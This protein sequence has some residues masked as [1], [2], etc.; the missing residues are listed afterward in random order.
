MNYNYN[1]SDKLYL[2]NKKK[3]S[4][5]LSVYKLIYK[6]KKKIEKKERKIKE[7][8]QESKNVF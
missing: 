3:H 6:K 2:V 4:F 5:S 7:R 8:N 1:N